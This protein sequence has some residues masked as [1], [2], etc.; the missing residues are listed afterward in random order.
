[1]EHKDIGVRKGDHQL[2]T[3]RRQWS[4]GWALSNIVRG[5]VNK[6]YL[7]P[8]LLA[9]HASCTNKGYKSCIPNGPLNGWGPANSSGFKGETR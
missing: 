9:H 7:P 1:M 6:A 4:S 5:L 2:Q 8:L 3:L